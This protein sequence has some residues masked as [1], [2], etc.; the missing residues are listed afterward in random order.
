MTLFGSELLI[1]IISRVRSYYRNTHSYCITSVLRRGE[2]IHVHI[3][4]HNE[5]HKHMH[6]HT[7]T[8][9]HT[10]SHTHIYTHMYIHTHIYRKRKNT[11]K[12]P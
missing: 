12:R 6:T 11:G 3:C 8:S 7:H 10:H 5:T 4:I 1:E 2:D 9:I